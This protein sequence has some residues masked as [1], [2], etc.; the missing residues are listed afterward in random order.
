MA[1]KLKVTKKSLS[2]HVSTTTMPE[3]DK[4]RISQGIK[5]IFGE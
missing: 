1:K 4:L 3:E 5:N 2:N